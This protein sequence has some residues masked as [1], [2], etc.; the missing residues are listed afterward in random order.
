MDALTTAGLPSEAL[1]LLGQQFGEKPPRADL[2]YLK[3]RALEELERFEEAREVYRA[4]LE[5]QPDPQLKSFLEGRL[6][7][8]LTRWT[9]R[10]QP[11]L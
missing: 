7:T 4:A 2:L 10:F 8:D 5:L 3:G 1:K 6:Q 11:K 9:P